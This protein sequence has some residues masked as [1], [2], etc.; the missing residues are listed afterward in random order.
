MPQ[1]VALTKLG[2]TEPYKSLTD[3]TFIDEALKKVQK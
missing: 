3:F 1:A 2:L